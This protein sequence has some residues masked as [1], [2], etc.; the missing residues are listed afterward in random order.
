MFD[1]TAPGFDGPAGCPTQS[2]IRFRRLWLR[3]FFFVRRRK[4]K[5]TKDAR[6]DARRVPGRETCP[7]RLNVVNT[8]FQLRHLIIWSSIFIHVTSESGD[9]R[10]RNGLREQSVWAF[11]RTHHWRGRRVRRDPDP[12]SASSKTRESFRFTSVNS[13][14]VFVAGRKRR[15]ARTVVRRSSEDR[16]RGDVAAAVGSFEKKKKKKRRRLEDL[17]VAQWVA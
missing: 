1:A 13:A 7:S 14:S 15:D 11:G 17:V 12:P 9:A 10:V 5:K 4:N 8:E 6:A 2:R 16:N 3:F